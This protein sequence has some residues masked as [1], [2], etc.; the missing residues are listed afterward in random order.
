MTAAAP[1]ARDALL[2]LLLTDYP[3][4]RQRLTG[5][6]G[7][8]DLAADALQDTYVRLERSGHLGEVRN[9]RSY[10]FRMALNIAS[11]IRRGEVRH[12]SVADVE[13][14]TSIVD[15]TPGPEQVAEARSELA[16][17]QRA[18]DAMPERRRAIFRRSWV[19][20]VPDR[21]IAAEF[22]LSERT[23]RHELLTATRFLH[24]A[25]RN[26]PRTELPDRLAQ[27]SFI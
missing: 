9:P 15:D 8:A 27:V 5:R 10:L 6:L 23:I 3:E 20:G 2:G 7:S 26:N 1:C 16:V 24:E 21:E 25:T 14:L 13:T 19:D 18:L 22:G 17:V 12:L 11:N 4:F